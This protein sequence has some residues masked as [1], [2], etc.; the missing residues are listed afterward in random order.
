[1]P[2][3]DY[4]EIKSGLQRLYLEDNRPWLVGF[5]GHQDTTIQ[6]RNTR[7]TRMP[8]LPAI[9]DERMEQLIEFRESEAV[10]AMN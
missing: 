2:G 8:T 4:Q 10:L 6:P 5:S 3:T 9:R 1:M 7:N